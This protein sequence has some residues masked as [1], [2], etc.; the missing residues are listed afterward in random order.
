MFICK[1]EGRTGGQHTPL[2]H[3]GRPTVLEG[4]L[5]KHYTRSRE[6]NAPSTE[7]PFR[8]DLLVYFQRAS[9]PETPYRPMAK[10]LENL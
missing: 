1:G 6:Q 9:L 3:T 10:Y 7:A 8:S 5:G 2:A 4:L